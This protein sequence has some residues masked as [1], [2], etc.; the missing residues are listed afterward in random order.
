MIGEIYNIGTQKERSVLDVVTKICKY[1]NLNPMDKI[2]HVKDRAFNDQR[3]Y[4][5]DK[6]LLALGWQEKKDW[7]SGIEETIKWYIDNGFASYWENGNVEAA[8]VVRFNPILEVI[9]WP[10]SLQFEWG[11]DVWIFPFLHC[12]CYF[13]CR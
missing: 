4:I 11:V 3:Y 6:K 9:R 1:F 12:I 2:K 13:L 10:E 8:L 5:C 7:E